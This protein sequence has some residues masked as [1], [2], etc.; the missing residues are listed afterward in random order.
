MG[1]NVRSFAIDLLTELREGCPALILITFGILFFI[2][3]L[4]A[5]ASDPVAHR[6]QPP[7]QGSS[8][9]HLPT[10]IS[11]DPRQHEPS[12]SGVAGDHLVWEA[13]R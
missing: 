7:T 9:P 13:A 12:S 5:V 10:Q 8:F 2:V 4:A 11:P 6:G 1:K 3:Q